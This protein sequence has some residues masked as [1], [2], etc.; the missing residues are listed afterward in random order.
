MK[1]CFRRNNRMSA[2]ALICTHRLTH[3]TSLFWFG[4][5]YLLYSLNSSIC[6]A[7]H[8]NMDVQ[9]A[10]K[11]RS[12]RLARRSNGRKRR[13]T[14]KTHLLYFQ[15][16]HWYLHF[17]DVSGYGF[18]PMSPW[19][20]YRLTESR[21]LMVGKPVF[22]GNLVEQHGVPQ[23]SSYKLFVLGNAY[24]SEWSFLLRYL[25][26]GCPLM[27]YYHSKSLKTPM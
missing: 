25:V 17:L 2:F 6:S 11:R 10:K 3:R 13:I 16:T 21:S 12:M 14:E 26:I 18:K 9:P 24:S 7:E 1:L 23:Y 22:R 27:A 15:R 8:Q 5:W 19:R 4:I 20:W